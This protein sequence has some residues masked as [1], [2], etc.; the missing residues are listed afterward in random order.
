MKANRRGKNEEVKDALQKRHLL[1]TGNPEGI[2][3]QE[4][5]GT[6]TEGLTWMR[7]GQR[8]TKLRE[9]VKTEM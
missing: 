6:K 9:G 4:G 3:P 7:K 2:Q 1:L 8:E 5:C